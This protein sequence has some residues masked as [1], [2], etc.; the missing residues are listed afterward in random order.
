[1]GE[2]HILIVPEIWWLSKKDW[3]EQDR[4]LRNLF[5]V[6]YETSKK[7]KTVNANEQKVLVAYLRVDRNRPSVAI[8]KNRKIFY[9]EYWIENNEGFKR[10]LN[11]R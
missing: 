10:H 7:N 9:R 1:L 5:S 8:I 6:K 2:S 4:R 3:V 11:E